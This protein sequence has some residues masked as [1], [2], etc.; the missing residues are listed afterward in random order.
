M[1]QLAVEAGVSPSFL[2]HV[3]RGSRKASLET[4]ARLCSVL[5]TTPNYLLQD[6]FPSMSKIT[7]REAEDSEL[8]NRISNMIDEHM[9]RS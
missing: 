9:G 2:G 6:S 8:L 4:L 5:S 1:A 7:K 3:E